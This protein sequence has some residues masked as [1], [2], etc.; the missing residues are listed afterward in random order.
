M[1]GLR[2][3]AFCARPVQQLFRDHAQDTYPSRNIRFLVPFTPGSATHT[4]ARLLANKMSMTLGRT[5]NLSY[6]GLF[7]FAL[8][9]TRSVVSKPSLKNP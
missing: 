6:S 3:M 1:L 8:A 9:L 2:E 7:N 4:L 5:D